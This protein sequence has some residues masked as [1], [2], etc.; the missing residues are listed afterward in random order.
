MYDQQPPQSIQS[1]EVVDAMGEWF[2]F[3]C[4]GNGE[5][6]VQPFGIESYARAYAEGQR[7]RLGLER[8]TTI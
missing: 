1:V 8:F 4:E 7:I 2:V 3:I 5:P 6:V